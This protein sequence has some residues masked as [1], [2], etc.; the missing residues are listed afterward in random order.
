[1]P[2]RTPTGRLFF[3]IPALL[4]A[5]AIAGL[6]GVAFQRTFADFKPLGVELT[7][8]GNV[9][10]VA[11][12][13]D[14]ETGSATGLLAG[15]M[16]FDVAG[17]LPPSLEAL[18]SRLRSVQ[19]AT[20]TVQRGDTVETVQYQR[21]PLEVDPV[22]PTLATIGVLYLL[23]GLYT[24]LRGQHAALFVFWCLASAALYLLS[25]RLPPVDSTDR[26]IF[27]VDQ[28]ARNLLPALTLHLFL[29]FPTTLLERGRL[30]WLAPLLY[31]PA[32]GLLT[33]HADQV[34]FAG[35][36]LFGP[37]TTTQL[38][39][40]DRLELFLLVGMAL[41]SA[42]LLLLRFRQRLGWEQRRQ[43]QWV[44]TGV[45][46]GYV[47]FLIF[48]QTPYSFG[49]STPLWSTLL[50]VLPL[51]LVPLAFAYAIFKY[52]LLDLGLILRDA[53]AYS[54]AVV[55][56][57]FG[58]QV[59]RTMIEQGVGEDLPVSR[60]M[61]TF[62][63]GLV[64]AGVLAPT[65]N[66]VSGGLERWRH[67]G[68]WGRRRLLGSLGRELLHERDLDQLCR[69]LVEQLTD[70]FVVRVDLFLLVAEGKLRA[71]DDGLDVGS[72]KHDAPR[73]LSLDALG[74]DF[75]RR[76]VESIS[77][78]G[79]PLAETTDEQRLFTAGYRYA[80]PVTVQSHPIGLMVISYKY[81]EEPLDGEDLELIRGLLNQAAL[82][83]ENAR[84]LTEV[85][86]QL[87]EVSRL[88]AYNEG[89]LQ[90]SPAGIAVLGEERDDG[91]LIVSANRAFAG[92]FGREAIVPGQSLV[93]LLPVRPL[94]DVGAGPLEVAYCEPSGEERYFQLSVAGYQAAGAGRRVLVLQDVSERV[95]MEFELREKEHLASLGMLAAGV[96]HEVNTPLTGISSY[97]QF[98]LD[99]TEP[100]D[101]RYKILQKMERQTFRASQI[102][103]NLLD[104]ARN[105]RG[106]MHRV[107]LSAAVSDAVQLLEMRA[108][109][110]G[111]VIDW[112]PPEQP[113]SVLGNEG[114]LHQVVTNLLTN[115]FD[116]LNGV[117]GERRITVEVRERGHR[118]EV[119]VRD[120]GPGIPEERLASIF[121]PFF[122]SK[123]GR[124]GTGLGLAIT[125]NIVRR[126]GGEILAR[127]V[128][129]GGAEFTVGL[130]AYVAV[131][132]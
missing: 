93:E 94:P 108:S 130:P 13:V 68:L 65:K 71:F 105:R 12:V 110:A 43:M 59:A 109:K 37:A 49:W 117:S 38:A 104:F 83:I 89:I 103:N 113:A 106:E 102:V 26:L 20:V 63:A 78:V 70:T 99:D 64:V 11:D 126:H 132:G 10:L 118:F 42:G 28:A 66:A 22:Y 36:R 80:F 1:M 87:A 31:L 34:F 57:L 84:L 91:D 60:A 30:R 77:G 48:Y 116:A 5:L 72:G 46:A 67:R 18:E 95:T 82:A 8:L 73:T 33:F 90:S 120:S 25:P 7:R 74:G 124:G 41:V 85:R 115:A 16:I 24:C 29:V 127:N 98:L 88:E 2:A 23:I 44:L 35:E 100:E 129:G 17:E 112:Q 62:A 27:W 9:Y 121:K 97:A 119:V 86:H 54:A 52:K 53:V 15:D 47:P 55:V 101:P 21:P 19:S 40:I 14:G 76:D 107:D 39:A 92:F 45:V 75:W 32:L 114:E 123:L 6:G 56:G 58:F 3:L 128:D 4:L 61:L 51:A 111:A 79:L 122:S 50:A 81:D 131:A 96:A 125:Y 69:R